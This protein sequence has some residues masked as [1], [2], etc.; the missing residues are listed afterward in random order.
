MLR[1]VPVFL[2]AACS[3]AS[4]PPPAKPTPT[5][6]TTANLAG[7]RCSNGT[8]QCRQPGSEDQAEQQPPAEG[9]KRFEV[10]LESVTGM[11]WVKVGG[12]QVYKDVE[13]AEDCFYLDLPVGK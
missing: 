4:A 11:V 5:G 3:G 10:R 9:T 12:E 13:R 7:H 8:C 1:F 2:L 6:G